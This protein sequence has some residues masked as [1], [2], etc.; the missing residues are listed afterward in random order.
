MSAQ[1]V[2]EI[3]PWA[4]FHKHSTYSF[5]ACRFQKRKKD[6]QVVNLLGSLSVKSAR[7]TLV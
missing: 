2:D 1:N 7:K 6:S 5:Y 3:D 4:Q